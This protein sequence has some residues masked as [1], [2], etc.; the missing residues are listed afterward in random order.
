MWRQQQLGMALFAA[1]GLAAVSGAALSMRTQHLRAAAGRVQVVCICIFGMPALL[2]NPIL[3]VATKALWLFPLLGSFLNL[4]TCGEVTHEY[5]E[6]PSV[7]LPEAGFVNTHGSLRRL[8]WSAKQR[9]YMAFYVFMIFWVLEIAAALSRFSVAYA[10]EHWYFTPYSDR[11]GFGSNGPPEMRRRRKVGVW[12]CI[13][14]RG[15]VVGLAFHLG[16]FSFG[17]LVLA[18]LRPVKPLLAWVAQQVREK[19]QNQVCEAI[20]CVCAECFACFDR[21]VLCAGEDAYMDIAMN[22]TGFCASSRHTHE[23]FRRETASL[24]LLSGMWPIFLFG[25][26]GLITSC[27]VGIIH[28]IISNTASAATATSSHAAQDSSQTLVFFA[29]TATAFIVTLGFVNL[30]DTVSGTML[31]CWALEARRLRE[32]GGVMPQG[33]GPQFAPARLYK[34]IAEGES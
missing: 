24:A 12:Q 20:G 29:T 3:D 25:G 30:V 19:Q 34:L 9:F 31:Y 6:P 5:V 1:G 33:N 14:F 2:L 4:L 16:S 7:H 28:V 26:V 17:A 13:F 21:V 23:L 8:R 18:P 32:K 22:S 15:Y 11:T 27:S 10:V